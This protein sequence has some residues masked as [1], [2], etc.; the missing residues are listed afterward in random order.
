M[1]PSTLFNLRGRGRANKKQVKSITKRKLN[2]SM[3]EK[4]VKTDQKQVNETTFLSQI[5]LDTPLQIARRP[6]SS[7]GPPKKGKKL[8][9]RFN[10]VFKELRMIDKSLTKDKVL[11]KRKLKHKEN[12]DEDIIIDNKAALSAY[13]S[14]ATHKEQPQHLRKNVPREQVRP[15]VKFPPS[16]AFPK[17]M[18]AIN[19]FLLTENQKNG[20][21]TKQYGFNTRKPSKS[22]YTVT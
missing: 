17:E 19:K 6:K 2:C 13:K 14:K 7:T 18:A 20:A 16:K 5:S 3:I 8:L 4:G 11:I 22:L 15:I 9:E 21:K 12:R 1:F 10:K